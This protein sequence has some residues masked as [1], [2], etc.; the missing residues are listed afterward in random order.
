MNT[1][2]SRDQLIRI[3]DQAT[4]YQCACPAQVTALISEILNLYAYQEECLNLTDIDV[5]VHNVISTAAQEA[6]SIIEK[7]LTDILILE[8]WDLN[9]FAMPDQL[10]KRMVD[11]V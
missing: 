1:R 6:Y 10:K 7:C 4:L 11:S 5:A 2:Y 3:R 8:G 9:T